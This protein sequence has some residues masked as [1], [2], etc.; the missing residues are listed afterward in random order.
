M[1]GARCRSG[2]SQA[3]GAAEPDT[4]G[5][6]DKRITMPKLTKRTH[7]PLC[8]NDCCCNAGVSPAITLCTTNPIAFP[9]D[10]QRVFLS[11][12]RGCHEVTGE[13]ILQ[14]TTG[15]F[16]RFTKTTT[17]TQNPLSG[18]GRYCRPVFRVRFE[19]ETRL[20]PKNEHWIPA[21]AGM[22]HTA[23][24]EAVLPYKSVGSICEKITKRTQTPLSR[25]EV[26]R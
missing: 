19:R 10:D 7:F 12:G 14:R 25:N 5:Y 22:T 6:N 9:D 3:L 21:F 4:I 18:N 24:P 8:H 23:E 1:R 26:S 17:R 11:L 20:L 16:S 15:I 13:G 2:P